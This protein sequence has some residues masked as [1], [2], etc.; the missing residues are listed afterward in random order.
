MFALIVLICG[1]FTPL[2]VIAISSIVPW[3]CRIPKQ[4]ASDREKVELRRKASFRNL[5]VHPPTERGVSGLGREQLMHI[6]DSLGLSSSMWDYFDAVLT[7]GLLRRKVRRRIEYLGMDDRLIRVYPHGVR[8]MEDEEVKM[9]CVERGIDVVGKS[10]S[11]VRRGLSAWLK[12]AE[13]VPI[14]KLLLTR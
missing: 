13:K 9:A 3:T 11:D 4:I 6:N 7:N 12:S 2:V 5:T 1:E 8:E 10:E 14:E